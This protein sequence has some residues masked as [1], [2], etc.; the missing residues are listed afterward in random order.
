[1]VD[2]GTTQTRAR[3]LLQLSNV[4]DAA[5]LNAKKLRVNRSVWS[6]WAMI[7]RLDWDLRL[8]WRQVK[9]VL[10]WDTTP[11][12]PIAQMMEAVS[13]S[14]TSVHILMYQTTRCN[15][16]EDSHIHK[17]ACRDFAQVDAFS[18]FIVTG[19]DSSFESGTLSLAAERCDLALDFRFSCDEVVFLFQPWRSWIYVSAVTKLGFLVS[20]VTKMDLF[21][22]WRSWIFVS[23]V[24][25]LDFCFS[26]DKV[27][28]MFQLWRIWICFSRDVVGFGFS[29]DKVGFLF[30][31]WRSW[32][33]VSAITKLD[34][35][36]SSDEVGFVSAVTNLDFCFSRDVVGFV[37]VVTNLDLFQ[38]WRSWVWFQP[39]QS[40]ISVSA[41]TKLDFCFS[42]CE[43]GFLFQ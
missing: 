23:A 30:Q 10:L 35:C 41:V 37:S 42:R 3:S 25:K 21:Q 43:V 17:Y 15:I 2:D 9:V 6:E 5:L 33:S 20:A 12:R 18:S 39:W 31:P 11:C 28:F 19:S 34:F 36:F 4:T 1:M 22:P 8:S 29:R 40:W 27:G 14:E 7:N 13:V 26:R 32:I 24:T 16:P 38:P